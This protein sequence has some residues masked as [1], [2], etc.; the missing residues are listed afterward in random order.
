MNNR[1]IDTPSNGQ[2][3]GRILHPHSKNEPA[4][5]E[6]RGFFVASRSLG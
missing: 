3:D 2:R 5:K 1:N 4:G 6:F